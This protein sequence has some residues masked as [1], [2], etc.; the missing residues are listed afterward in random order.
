MLLFKGFDN[1]GTSLINFKNWQLPKTKS[2]RFIENLIDYSIFY[3]KHNNCK[4]SHKMIGQQ[5]LVRKINQCLLFNI[6]LKINSK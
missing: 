6:Q 1:E 5:K 3:C 4:T 2:F